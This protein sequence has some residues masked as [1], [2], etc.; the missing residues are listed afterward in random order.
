[1]ED[2]N[3][4]TGKLD[5]ALGDLAG[6]TGLQLLQFR[7]VEISFR[8]VYVPMA[9]TDWTKWKTIIIDIIPA[10]GTSANISFG[11]SS[12]YDVIGRISTKWT[13]TIF[14][15]YGQKDA[16]ILAIFFGASPNIFRTD[17]M[18]FQGL[19]NV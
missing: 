15:P 8:S 18:T 4:M 14:C 12:S 5:T 19:G 17:L 2:F 3:D 9:G 7:E 13:R 6:H 11:F 16:P 10:A 1:M